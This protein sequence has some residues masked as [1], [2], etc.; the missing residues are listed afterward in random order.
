MG[1]R[2]ELE[3]DF[4]EETEIASTE[5]GKGVRSAKVESQLRKRASQTHIRS[6]N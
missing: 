4:M 6:S 1:I 2:Q 3:E 5:G